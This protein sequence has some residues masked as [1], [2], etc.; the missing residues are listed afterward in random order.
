MVFGLQPRDRYFLGE[1][2]GRDPRVAVCVALFAEGELHGSL[3]AKGWPW[4]TKDRVVKHAYSV[5]VWVD[6][7]P[8]VDHPRLR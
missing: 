4:G 5:R 7:Y 2:E 6:V 8:G 1:A 3:L